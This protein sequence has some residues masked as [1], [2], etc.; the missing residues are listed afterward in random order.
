MLQVLSPCLV[1]HANAVQ[2]VL[3]FN[4]DSSLQAWCRDSQSNG[5][6]QPKTLAA[7][8]A[9]LH[10]SIT[11][12]GVVAKPR[13]TP[14]WMTKIQASILPSAAVGLKAILVLVIVLQPTL[15]P[16]T[17]E[18]TTDRY[19]YMRAQLLWL[20]ITCVLISCNPLQ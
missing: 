6:N 3:Q 11:V 4:S 17:E 12:H 14:P 8:Q 13:C 9:Q 10:P 15:A 18:M 20:C 5:H 16:H 2:E 7:I 1:M 19:V